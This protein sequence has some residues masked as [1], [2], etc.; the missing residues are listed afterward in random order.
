[1][2]WS[3]CCVVYVEGGR[4]Q[5][6][7][8]WLAEALRVTCLLISW[9]RCV[10][11]VCARIHACTC[12]CFVCCGRTRGCACLHLCGL[13][14]PACKVHAPYYICHLWH[15]WFCHTFP[16]YLINDAILKKKLLNIK[17]LI[18]HTTFVWKIYHY[19]MNWARYCHKCLC[20]FT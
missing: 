9:W 10:C 17:C 13:S 1:M 14:Y 3:S 5:L 11:L 19:S 8:T 15:I 18:S 12:A 16:H 2:P 6:L 4:N 7:T 20:V